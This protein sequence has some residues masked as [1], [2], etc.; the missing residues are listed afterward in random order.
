MRDR[1]H[2]SR[3]TLPLLLAC[4]LV[5]I[6]AATAQTPPPR[7]V[8]LGAATLSPTT[9]AAQSTNPGTLPATATVTVSIAT[10]SDVLSGTRATIDL[11]EDSNFS[12]VTYSV[13]DGNGTAGRVQTVTLAGGGIA[14]L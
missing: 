8:F 2:S 13:T 11:T 9:I 10:S 14:P 5:L 1:R 7:R 12:G 3:V 6:G 4:T